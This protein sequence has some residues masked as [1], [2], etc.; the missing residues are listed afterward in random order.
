[1]TTGIHL[2]LICHFADACPKYPWSNPSAS[3][4]AKTLLVHRVTP[5]GFE[6][7]TFGLPTQTFNHYAAPPVLRYNILF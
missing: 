1:M 6:P 4:K 2:L 5:V 3:L 7:T